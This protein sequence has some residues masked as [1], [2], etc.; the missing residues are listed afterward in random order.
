[1]PRVFSM[2]YFWKRYWRAASTVRT[3]ATA[4]QPRI[5]KQR[6]TGE[7]V[8]ATVT[9][10]RKRLR[11]LKGTQQ[12]HGAGKQSEGRVRKRCCRPEKTRTVPGNQETGWG[13]N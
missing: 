7:W 9:L 10:I 4:K 13:G 11:P 2:V 5:T 8:S 1:M 6:W 3:A 12:I